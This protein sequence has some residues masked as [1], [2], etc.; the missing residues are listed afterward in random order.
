MVVRSHRLFATAALLGITAALGAADWPQFLGPNRNGS[1]P[2]TGLL[3]KWG[4]EGPKVVWK[5]EGGEGYS[6]IAVVRGSLY[7]VVQ[8][9]GEEVLLSLDVKNGKEVWKRSLGP[10]YKNQYGDGP[11]STPTVDGE[12]LFVQSATGGLFC[13]EAATGK[14]LWQHDLFKEYKA[15]N[16]SWGVS[17]SPLV[18]GD[19]VMTMPGDPGGVV[20]F[21]KQTGKQV[22]KTADDKAGY[23]SPVTM[24]AGGKKQAIFFTAVG[25]LAVEPADGKELWRVPWKTEYDVNIATPLVIGDRVFVSSG[26]NVGCAMLAPAASG[27]PKV[28]WEDKGPKSVMKSYW[29]TAVYHDKHIYGCSS[30]HDPPAFIRCVNAETGKEVWSTNRFPMCNLTLTDGHLYIVTVPGE[31]IVAAATPKGYEEKGRAK[32]LNKLD[33]QVNSPTIA[34]KKMYLRDFKSII[35]LDIAK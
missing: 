3:T 4:A 32:V 26:E 29:A 18:D 10:A 8:R 35:C 17:A 13:V 24:T 34:D 22:W 31:L 9:S 27:P 15:K 25:V 7:T 28:L 14:V 11:R 30:E 1:S 16:L 12:R 19:L 6:G 33:R 20:A 23:S 5:V 21:N 2:E